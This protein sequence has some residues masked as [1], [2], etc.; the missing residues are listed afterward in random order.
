MTYSTKVLEGVLPEA[1]T[2][3]RVPKVSALEM[4]LLYVNGILQTQEELVSYL[5]ADDTWIFCQL[6]ECQEI[7]TVLSY[8]TEKVQASVSGLLTMTYQ[9]TLEKMKQNQYFFMVHCKPKTNISYENC[10]VKQHHDAEY[11]SC[12]LNWNLSEELMVIV[13]FQKLI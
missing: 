2:T 9:S 5:H 11:L 12:Y 1:E 3:K 4:V 13:P 6:K 7:G 10:A 8:R